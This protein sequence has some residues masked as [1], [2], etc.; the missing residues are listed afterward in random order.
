MTLKNLKIEKVKIIKAAI[1]LI[2]SVEVKERMRRR[3]RDKM[4]SE[5]VQGQCGFIEAKGITNAV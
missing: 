4:K 2:P 5:V 3:A 1:Q